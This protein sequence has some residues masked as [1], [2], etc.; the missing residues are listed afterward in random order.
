[1]RMKLLGSIIYAE[2]QIYKAAIHAT[3][4]SFADSRDRKGIITAPLTYLPTL[5]MLCY[6]GTS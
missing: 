4:L 2:I 5:E 6:A 3:L 1:M